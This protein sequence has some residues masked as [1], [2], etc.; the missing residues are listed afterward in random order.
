MVFA[1]A[2]GSLSP[3][4]INAMDANKH[5]FYESEYS[6]SMAKSKSDILEDIILPYKSDGID[7][8]VISE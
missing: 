8:K 4:Y 3:K 1:E 6:P 7:S 5:S 2:R